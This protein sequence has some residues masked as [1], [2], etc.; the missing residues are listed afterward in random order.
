MMPRN[1]RV[2]HFSTS[3][4]T[5][6]RQSVVYP[7]RTSMGW[8]CICFGALKGLQYS[9]VKIMGERIGGNASF[10]IEFVT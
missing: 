9:V 8:K 6:E 2:A 5:S 10:N 7:L 4:A 3:S 1:I